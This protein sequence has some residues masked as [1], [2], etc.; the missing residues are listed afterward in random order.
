[1][2]LALEKI[3][4]GNEN[5]GIAKALPTTTSNDGNGEVTHLSPTFPS[6]YAYRPY[7][8]LCSTKPALGFRKKNNST[9]YSIFVLGGGRLV[10]DLQGN[11][12][13]VIYLRMDY[14]CY[15]KKAFPFAFFL[16]NSTIH[17]YCI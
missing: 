7:L 10:R 11:M 12:Y 15:Q 14:D 1:M 3:S 13:F 6:R 17:M 2:K 16:Y 5:Y 8:N 9:F 4:K